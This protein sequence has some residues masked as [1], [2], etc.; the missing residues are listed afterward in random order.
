KPRDLAQAIVVALSGQDELIESMEVAGPGFVNFRLSGKFWGQALERVLKLGADYGR[1]QPTGRKVL[2]EYV[3]ANPTGPLHVGHGRGAALGDALARILAFIGDEVSCEYYVNDAGRQIRILG[4]SVL[5][6][7]REI[8]GQKVEIPQDFYQ[9]DYISDIARDLS[10]SLGPEFEALGEDAKAEFLSQKAMNILLDEIKKELKGFGIRHDTWFSEKSLY[11]KHLV[12][13]CF[14]FLDKKGHTYRKAGA[15]WFKSTAFGDDKDRV[16]VKS[17]GE[18]T[19]FASDIA[20]HK[21]KFDRGFDFLI[22]LWGSDHH[23]YI[24]RV[25]AAI[26]ALG[27]PKGELD[28][29]LL[30]FVNLF[31]DGE[32]VSMS[33]RNADFVTLAEVLK[34]VGPDAARFMYL[35]RNHDSTLDF[36]LDLAKSQSRDNPVFYVQYVCARVNSLLAKAGAISAMP[37]PA[38]LALG[39]EL[40]IIKSLA[41]FPETVATAARRLEPHLLTVY[42]TG[43]AKLFHQY[44][45]A[46]RLVDPENPALTAARLELAKAIKQVIVIGLD[47]L[48]VSAPEKM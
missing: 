13:E 26:E 46:Y 7:L 32:L 31:K 40:E 41:S 2:I 11:D 24:P 10:P 37:D 5:A 14:D 25:K 33:K 6:R 16:L 47:L 22:D 27:H 36:D 15:L 3:S 8:Q 1:G 21:G 35:T 28:V 44:Y 38:L 30:Q 45:G 18:M 4:E 17:D 20:Y 12:E 42:L 43:L 48:G 34:E 9:G 39:D 23:G 29:V 19:Y